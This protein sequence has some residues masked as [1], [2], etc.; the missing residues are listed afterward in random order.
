MK[1][2]TGCALVVCVL[3]MVL[4]GCGGKEGGSPIQPDPQSVD[5][6]GSWEGPLGTIGTLRMVLQQQGS[7]VSGIFADPNGDGGSVTGSVSGNRLVCRSTY[8]HFSTWVDFTGS[9]SDTA[10]TGSFTISN[11]SSGTLTLIRSSQSGACCTLTGNCT[12]TT[13]ANCIGGSTWILASVCNPNTCQTPPPAGSCCA[14]NG[15][16]TVTT[17][18]G[19]TG[20][21]TWTAAGV[22]VPNTCQ[23]SPPPTGAC[24]AATSACVVTT[25]AVCGSTDTWTQAGVCDP[26]PCPPVPPL[27]SCC[28]VNDTCT[29]TPY[30]SCAGTGQWT[31]SGVCM[32]NPCSPQPPL[33]GM[34][35]IP[36]GN[37][38]LGQ[39]GV[40]NAE[41]VN[42]FYVEGFY[43]DIYEVSNAKYKAFMDAGGYTTEAYWNPVGWGLLVASGH[44]QPS[45][46]TAPAYHGGGIAGNEQFPV[47]GVSWYEADAYC[48]W[49]GGR[50]PTEA[51][52]EKAAK[53]GC[54]IH[55][56]PGQCEASDTQTYPWGEDFNSS[57]ANYQSSGDPYDDS[58]YT[59]PVGYYDG[60]NHGGYQTINS[61]SPYGLYDVAGNVWEWCSTQWRDYPYNPSDG[62]EIPPVSEVD[63]SLGRVLRGGSFSV[64]AWDSRDWLRCANRIPERILSNLR[65]MDSVGFRCARAN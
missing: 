49:A 12:V 31:L 59:T 58:G 7:S 19:C 50:L 62:R 17:E 23:I 52:W 63:G 34:V 8:S 25:R 38:R 33:T 55:G 39:V 60:G 30:S 3:V 6:T 61:R 51:E 56:A 41:P 14:V 20:T 27:G 37:V 28:A 35:W 10:I 53:G 29:V 11:G 21:G 45:L 42:D 32:P 48:R 2:V 18:A 16:C 54:E 43:I 65:E 13:Q 26:N 9:V 47:C 5:V 4:A 40:L 36:P 22:C 46:W 57:Q 64:S 15:A 1:V 44:T 24:C